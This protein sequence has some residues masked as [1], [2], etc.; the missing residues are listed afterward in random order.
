MHSKPE[1]PSGQHI[2]WMRVASP[3]AVLNGTSITCTQVLAHVQFLVVQSTVQILLVPTDL[4]VT[5]RLDGLCKHLSV[6]L[7]QCLT[8]RWFK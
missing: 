3:A 5:V 8:A 4:C 2:L 1:M 6:A 7:S